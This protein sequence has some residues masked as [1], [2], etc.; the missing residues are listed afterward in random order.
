M[1]ARRMSMTTNTSDGCRSES[2]HENQSHTI[3]M[4]LLI[5]ALGS[6][7]TKLLMKMSLLC[8]NIEDHARVEIF[9]VDKII[10]I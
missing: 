6:A 7:L 10:G 8:Y 9:C 4:S 5:V 1:E 3:V 2:R